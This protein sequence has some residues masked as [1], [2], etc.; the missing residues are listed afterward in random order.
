[1]VDDLKH[2]EPNTNKTKTYK[3]FI[4]LIFC[5][6]KT[7]LFESITLVKTQKFVTTLVIWTDYPIY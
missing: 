4:N 3:I 2:N 1:M 7:R 6:P 5:T